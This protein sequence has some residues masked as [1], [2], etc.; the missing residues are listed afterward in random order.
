MDAAGSG[1][2]ARKQQRLDE[3]DAGNESEARDE[4]R[5]TWMQ[6]KK[7][8]T[9]ESVQGFEEKSRQYLLSRWTHY[10]RLQ[11]FH[12]RVR[13]GNGCF[14]LDMVTG[15]LLA[16]SVTTWGHKGDTSE[17]GN[18]AAKRSAVSTG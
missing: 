12:G 10:H 5:Q 7:P 15:K 1:V 18:N 6:K 4:R 17:K 13:N 11:Q 14:Q 16:I 2:P 9:D 3:Q 8:C